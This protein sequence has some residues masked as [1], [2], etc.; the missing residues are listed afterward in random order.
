M[1]VKCAKCQRDFIAQATDRNFAGKVE[2]ALR[3]VDTDDIIRE[4]LGSG[5]DPGANVSISF[6][7]DLFENEMYIGPAIEWAYDEGI[8]DIASRQWYEAVPSAFLKAVGSVIEKFWAGSQKKL[9]ESMRY[10]FVDDDDMQEWYPDGPDAT[11][12]FKL[13][14]RT[15]ERYI[16]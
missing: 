11:F 14:K 6:L 9:K 13:D 2:K 5:P 12:D 15:L 7:T 4:F 1:I 10:E 3:N 16:R 8:T